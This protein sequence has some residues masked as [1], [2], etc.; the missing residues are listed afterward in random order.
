MILSFCALN[1]RTEGFRVV[2]SK[3]PRNF[4]QMLV[5]MLS[6]FG[7]QAVNPVEVVVPN[8]DHD[9][10]RKSAL[11]QHHLNLSGE[12]SSADYSLPQTFVR[13]FR[14]N[15]CPGAIV[16]L[17]DERRDSLH[18]LIKAKDAL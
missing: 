13:F 7:R 9:Q 15:P 16:F 17:R 2:F 10:I 4:R 12:I 11:T 18:S 8:P 3:T 5:R 1:E 6:L 14:G